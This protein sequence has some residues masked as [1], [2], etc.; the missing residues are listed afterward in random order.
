MK[1]TVLIIIFFL[2][3]I[4]LQAQNPIFEWVKSN[5]GYGGNAE[6][7][8][9]E[10]DTN[11]N[12]YSIGLFSGTVDFD[13]S[14]SNASMLTAS[15]T[16]SWFIQKLDKNGNFIWVRS[17]YN[18]EGSVRSFKVDD[19]GDLYIIGE[20]SDSID[21]DPG[22]L[23]YNLVSQGGWD[24]FI[25]KLSANGNFIW[26]KSFGGSNNDRGESLCIDPQGN[27]YSHGF[28]TTQQILTRAREP[29]I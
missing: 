13:P 5:H 24:V 25:F 14:P 18:S 20:F 4:N 27:I 19:S 10:I 1:D 28:F 3:A 15:V 17:I 8:F 29:F 12:I 21:L 16:P 26:A 23:V 9:M 22:Y 6:S 7:Y 2:T 11:G